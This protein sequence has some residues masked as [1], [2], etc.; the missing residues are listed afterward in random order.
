MLPI[1]H[2]GP[3]SIPTPGLIILLGI[4]I[5]LT[6]S[7]K[8]SQK[9]G[10]SSSTIYNL[11]FL[12]LI[13]GVIFARLY[14]VYLY[15]EL[16]LENPLSLL[17]PNPNTLDPRAG[18]LGACLA[19]LIYGNRKKLGLWQTLD[20]LTSM[21]AVIVIALALSNLAS[22]DAYGAPTNLPWAIHLW[23]ADRHPTQIY[24]TLG[25]LFVL[26]L[27]YPTR[28]WITQVKPGGLFLIFLAA[29]SVNKLIIEVF[30]GDSIL[31]FNNLR[32]IQILSLSTLML[33]L[34]LLRKKLP[35]ISTD[36]TPVIE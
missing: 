6:F 19:A 35:E 5:G 20:A 11:V 9:L 36:S 14:Y 17:I 18:L 32:L 33:S 3:V 22:G 2:I 10:L 34:L 13:A 8:H 4:W 24:E 7:E 21:F 27:T 16:F 1:L 23:N 26:L 28:K 15:P 12:S 30:R 31:I 25:A 29:S